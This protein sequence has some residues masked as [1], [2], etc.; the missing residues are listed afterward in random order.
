MTV[1]QDSLEYQNESHE[2]HLHLT[3]CPCPPLLH[4]EDKNDEN[5]AVLF[6]QTKGKIRRETSDYIYNCNMLSEKRLAGKIRL[7]SKITNK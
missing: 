6:F 4:N 3:T 1:S 5:N 2:P 7:K